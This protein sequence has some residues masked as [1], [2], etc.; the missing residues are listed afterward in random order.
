MRIVVFGASG[1]CGRHFVRLA[2]ANGHAVSCVVRPQTPFEAP[3]PATVRRGDVLDAAFVEDAIGGHDAVMSALGM[4]YRHPWARRESPDDFTSRATANIIRGM[5]ARGVQRISIISGAGV[6]DSRPGLNL[7]MRLL[8]PISNLGPAYADL[9]RAEALLHASTLDWQAVR[10][11]SLTDAP[12]ASAVQVLDRFP[13]TATIPRESVAAYLLEQL[14]AP[15]FGL[16][17]PLI[18]AA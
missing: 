4:R 15:R 2:C 12:R 11:V 6:G 3:P 17:T 5:T 7:V 14:E 13:L 16:R 10:P 8:L 9:D 18:A 1:Q